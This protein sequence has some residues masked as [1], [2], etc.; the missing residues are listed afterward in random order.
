[1]S[2]SN[3]FNASS[4]LLSF[5]WCVLST[6]PHNVSRSVSALFSSVNICTT[7]LTPGLMSLNPTNCSTSAPGMCVS[8]GC[9]SSF[10]SVQQIQPV[11]MPSSMFPS[12]AAPPTFANILM[13]FAFRLNLIFSSLRPNRPAAFAFKPCSRRSHLQKRSAAT[14]RCFSERAVAMIIISLGP[15]AGGGSRF[16]R[17]SNCKSSRPAVTETYSSSVCRSGGGFGGRS[18]TSAGFS[19]GDWTDDCCLRYHGMA[20]SC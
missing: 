15:S 11:R 5:L 2:C 13:R 18:G 19:V 20:L 1:M 12:G 16:R 17:S 9:A 10:P 8:S 3:S 14:C 4:A 6:P 7:T